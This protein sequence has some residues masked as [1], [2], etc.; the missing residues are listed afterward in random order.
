LNTTHS[1]N[2]FCTQFKLFCLTCKY[3]FWFPLHQIRIL[4][5]FSIF[6]FLTITVCLICIQLLVV[7][8]IQ[9]FIQAGESLYILHIRCGS[10]FFSNSSHSRR[11]QYRHHYHRSGRLVI[12]MTWRDWKRLWPAL[13]D[14]PELNGTQNFL[15]SFAILMLSHFFVHRGK[16]YFNEFK[17]NVYFK[18][19]C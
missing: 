12:L 6:C 18:M 13:K 7:W 15:Q 19:L 17:I 9:S 11:Q 4:S 1:I 3:L 8:F 16:I 10:R 14:S 2:N 5:Y